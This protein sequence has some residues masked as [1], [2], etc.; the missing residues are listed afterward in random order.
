MSYVAKVT[1]EQGG[2]EI[3]SLYRQ[4]RDHYG[5]LPNY[6]QA[7]GYFPEIIE[8]H[9]ALAQ[10][11]MQEGSLSAALKEQILLLVSG[12]N[13]SSY[14]IA[15]HMQVLQNLGVEA[16]LGR[17]LATDYTRAPVAEKEMALFRYADKLTRDGAH[18]SPADVDGLRRLG[19][20]DEA[21]VEAVLV[22]AWANFINR[23]SLGLG[24]VAEH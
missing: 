10:S 11:L 8:R 18:V 6:F 13:S 14:C 3:Q 22:V 24:L 19:W 17:K 12:V 9:N 1:E 4:I 2:P 21:I 5:F 7:L 20:S 16:S 23:V 15:I